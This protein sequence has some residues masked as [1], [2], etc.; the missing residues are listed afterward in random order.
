[1]CFHQ[2]WPGMSLRG[3]CGQPRCSTLS[4]NRFLCGAGRNSYGCFPYLMIKWREWSWRQ[5]APIWSC[6]IR[7]CVSG[8]RWVTLAWRTSTLHYIIWT[9]QGV[10]RSCRRSCSSCRR[11]WFRWVCEHFYLSAGP[12]LC[13]YRYV[14]SE[15]MTQLELFICV[16][17]SVLLEWNE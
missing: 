1:M 17:C 8:A 2:S 10:Q 11:P 14:E 3:R 15:C 16:H 9:C 6:S 4:S 12:M 13:V 7:C 5:E